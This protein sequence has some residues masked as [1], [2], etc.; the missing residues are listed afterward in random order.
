MNFYLHYKVGNRCNYRLPI[1]WEDELRGILEINNEKITIGYKI[2]LKISKLNTDE[3]KRELERI[4]SNFFNQICDKNNDS[5]DFFLHKGRS[6][7]SNGE[8]FVLNNMISF[9]I[10]DQDNKIH[11]LPSSNE[12]PTFKTIVFTYYTLNDESLQEGPLND[13]KSFKQLILN[14]EID[15]YEFNSS[16]GYLPKIINDYQRVL[17]YFSGHADT[18]SL[19]LDHK[20]TISFEKII[21]WIKNNRNP[22][23]LLIFDCCDAGNALSIGYSIQDPSVK[24]ISTSQFY[25]KSYQSGDES[26]FLS[27]LKNV[28]KPGFDVL[29]LF[30]TIEFYHL[31]NKLVLFYDW[32]SRKKAEMYSPPVFYIDQGYNL[33]SINIEF[34][35]K[36][37]VCECLDNHIR[38]NAI[39]EIEKYYEEKPIDIS[40]KSLINMLLD[41]EAKELSHA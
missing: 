32:L 34:D 28:I 11:L 15:Y 31:N 19:I 17:F 18:N 38:L 2:H 24:F 23:Y 5:I 36:L 6:Q 33:D 20:A 12:T 3:K 40:I 13:V 41:K 14:P 29:C 37:N 30:N 35:A 26:R 4:F 25:V 9:T 16:E 1:N 10:V 22:E 27:C 39:D 21:S 8:K 7:S